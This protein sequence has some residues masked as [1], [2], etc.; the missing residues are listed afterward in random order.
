MF[1]CVYGTGATHRPTAAAA[2][3]VSPYETYFLHTGF[4]KESEKDNDIF[5]RFCP[6]QDIGKNCAKKSR[7]TFGNFGESPSPVSL[8]LFPFLF[9]PRPSRVGWLVGLGHDHIFPAFGSEKKGKRRSSL[10]PPPP[11]ER[12]CLLSLLPQ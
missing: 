3:D 1:S 7:A 5:P 6:K 8:P 9:F 11:N 10:L 2:Q 12:N 4:N